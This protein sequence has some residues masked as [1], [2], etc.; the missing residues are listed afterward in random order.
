[1]K[2]EKEKQQR[3]TL[4]RKIMEILVPE[5][6]AARQSAL[7]EETIR[8][9]LRRKGSITDLLHE[10]A[11]E[12]KLEAMPMLVTKVGWADWDYPIDRA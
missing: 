11:S 8:L 3:E 9:K 12:G 7:D 1:M 4:K 5:T 2:N 10:L 6:S